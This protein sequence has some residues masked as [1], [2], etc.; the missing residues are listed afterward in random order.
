MISEFKGEF[1]FLSN[2]WPAKVDYE[3]LEF[4]NVETAYQASKFEP[5][6]RARFVKMSPTEAKKAGK[7][8]GNDEWESR[9]LEIMEL[10]IRKKF[11]IPELS[12]L[13]KSTGNEELVEG[14]WWGDQYW[15]MCRGVGEN[16]LGKI[17]MKIR[18]ELKGDDKNVSTH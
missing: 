13:L 16:R 10:L 17:L 5:R 3:G 11:S 15:G 1:R 18:G 4:G 9:K 8:M 6:F 12:A 14:N 2:F 7:G